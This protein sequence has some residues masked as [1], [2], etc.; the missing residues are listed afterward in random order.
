ME[1]RDTGGEERKE[2][3]Q[4]ELARSEEITGEVTLGEVGGKQDW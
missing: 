3:G 1:R 4:L 2:K